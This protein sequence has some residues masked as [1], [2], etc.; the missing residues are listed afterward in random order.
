MSRLSK[1]AKAC[2]WP[3]VVAGGGGRQRHCL[4]YSLLR[5]ACDHMRAHARCV[6]TPGWSNAVS[7]MARHAVRLHKIIEG[8]PCQKKIKKGHYLLWELGIWCLRSGIRCRHWVPALVP[9]LGASI[10][11]GIVAHGSDPKM[12]F[13]AG[14]SSRPRA[15]IKPSS[16]E[17]G[18]PLRRRSGSD[19]RSGLCA[20][21]SIPPIGA[22][23]GQSAGPVT[24]SST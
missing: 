10:G 16:A 14:S 6:V 2:R 22:I 23:T 19:E 1:V 4:A 5:Q 15:V 20:T 12:S 13:G 18:L 9:A 21:L 8:M 24:R 11:A 7:C 17:A 3:A